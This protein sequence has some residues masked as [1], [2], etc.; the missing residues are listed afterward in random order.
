MKRQTMTYPVSRTTPTNRTTKGST[1][2]GTLSGHHE[3][4]GSRSVDNV[5][6]G[7]FLSTLDEMERFFDETLHRPFLGFSLTPFRQLLHGIG[8]MN[9]SR[10]NVDLCEEGGN[11]VLRADLPGMTR[12]NIDVSV[13]DNCL[14]ISGERRM[15]DNVDRQNYLRVE[16][17]YGSFSRSVLLPEGLDPEHISAHLQDGVLEIRIPRVEGGRKVK[18]IAIE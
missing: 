1:V 6:R 11:L 18:H 10:F 17:S 12:E 3:N 14:V 16:R 8:E 4:H 5:L 9:T 15:E 13:V 7:G 2:T